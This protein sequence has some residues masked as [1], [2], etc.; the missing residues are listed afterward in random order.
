[1]KEVNEQARYKNYAF[2]SYSHKPN[3]MAEAILLQWQLEWY[4]LPNTTTNEIKKSKYLRPIWR[5]Q[6]DGT[7][8]LKETIKKELAKSKKLIVICS[9]NAAKSP[10]IENDEVGYFI[11]ELK[12]GDDV[13]P[14]IIGGEPH[15]SI[16][17]NECFPR[18][19]LKYYKS[20]NR[21]NFGYNIKEKGVGRG[22]ATVK[23]VWELLGKD[24][25]FDVLW[26]RYKREQRKRIRF[27]ITGAIAIITLVA[28]LMTPINLSIILNEDANHNLPPLKEGKI[29]INGAE[30]PVENAN[31]VIEVK[32]LSVWL[33]GKD[34][35]IQFTGIY[36]DTL[37]T[38]IPIGFGF[39]H[40]CS[41]KIQRDNTFG[42]FSGHVKDKDGC[43]VDG[44]L[45]NIG[46]Y[47]THTNRNGYFKVLIPLEH[48]T[49][50]KSV[51]I[52]KDG[53][54]K[55]ESDSEWPRDS[56]RYMLR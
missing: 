51:S 23:V 25:D 13:I 43:F 32:N 21:E 22:M 48:Q 45:V 35:P 47:Q 49:C 53:V 3:D 2:I 28:Y 44:A 6:T 33:R 16:P 5:D 41:V 19:L 4:R 50:M 39:N 9:P 24:V 30:Y 31:S 40:T 15:A 29:I 56:L 52:Y 42:I 11:N 14:Y 26:Q 37:R 8:K 7:G 17:A 34:V 27:F 10:F 38:A 18:S 1:M 46:G 20:S 36:Y 12:R 55:F 54:G